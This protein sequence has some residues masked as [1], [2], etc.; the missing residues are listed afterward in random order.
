M[1]PPRDTL[2]VAG[3]AQALGVSE[4]TVWRYLKSGRLPG[5]T[6]GEPGAQ[7]TLIPAAAV[8]T[9]R[10]GRSG[11]D[12]EALRVE[13][14]RLASELAAARAERDA[15]RGRVRLLQRSLSAPLRPGLV[16][17]ALTRALEFTARARG[18]RVSVR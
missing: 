16:E 14:D 15:L 11:A 13:R 3:A 1:N 2:T 18:P 9:L 6:V 5:E 4:R 17:R 12:A 8:E 10:V 7:R